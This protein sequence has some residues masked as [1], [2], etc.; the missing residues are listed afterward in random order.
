MIDPKRPYSTFNDDLEKMNKLKE[1]KLLS[2]KAKRL[3]DFYY[4]GFYV[5]EPTKCNIVGFVDNSEI[6]IEVNSLLHSIHP[7]YFK[8]MQKSNFRINFDESKELMGKV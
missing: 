6:I 3:K 4:K 8:Q 7:A 5:K 1:L 2:D